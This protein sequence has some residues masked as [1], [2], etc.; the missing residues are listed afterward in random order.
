MFEAMVKH[1]ILI[2]V[3]TL[4]VIVLGIVAALKIPVQMIPDLEVRTIS[5]RTNWP[6]ATPQDVE[7]EILIEQEEHLRSVRGLQRIVSSA[8]FGR[9]QVELEFPFGINL[10][11]TLIEVI[12]ALS[13]VP[14]YPNNV[15]EPRI[16]ATSFSANSF[17]Y[18]RVTPLPGN[19]RNLNM[20]PMQDFIRDH[21]ASRMETVP[22]VS[23]ISVYGGAERQIQ[24]LVDPARLA[25][26]NLTVAQVRGAIQQRNR[27]VSGGEI[28]SGKRRYLLRT[29]GRVRDVEDLKEVIVDHQGDALT[30]LGEIAEI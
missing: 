4:I 16:Y 25:E 23:E 26:R 7:K 21:V 28:E 30:R 14:S 27:D 5:I 9:A 20:I 12:N 13:R 24:I 10:N 29:I 6:G 11:D 2:A 19:P 3:G 1:G 18:F 17:M 22:G 15:D 8:S